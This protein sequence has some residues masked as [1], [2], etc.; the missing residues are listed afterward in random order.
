MAHRA[1]DGII[2]A[3]RRCGNSVTEATDKCPACGI[4]APGIDSNC[5]NCGSRNYFW[6]EYGL[7]IGAGIAGTIL[8]GPLGA[9]A[10]A[11]GRGDTECV[12]LQCGQGWMPFAFPGG[13][14]STTRKYKI[15]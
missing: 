3:C 5:P 7:N 1:D 4:T 11:L 9:L 8:L 15:Q 13:K 14:L 2:K 12:C 6:K 10:A